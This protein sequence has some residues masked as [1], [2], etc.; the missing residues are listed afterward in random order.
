MNNRKSIGTAIALTL[1]FPFAGLIYS[2]AN[3][4][5]SWA[6]NAFW[7]AC[8]YLG[9]VFVFCPEGSILGM[10]SDAGRYA[11]SLMEMHNS[12]T[13][14]ST[15]FGQYLID[16]HTMDLYQPLMTYFISRFTDNAHVLFAVY[17][18]VFGFLYSRNIWYILDKLP[19]KKL[20][21]LFVLITLYFLV[22]PITQIN[23]ARM[24]TATHLF[25]YA[26][27]PY[28]LD[29]NKSRYWCVLLTPLIHFSFF[30]VAIFAVVWLFIPNNLKTRN[31]AA[32][33]I[34][35]ILFVSTMFFNELNLNSVSNVLAE[36][37]PE[38]YE[39][40][41]ES[42]VNEDIASRN[43]S[44]QAL[45]NW[46]VGASYKLES[47]CYNLLLLLLLP[48]IKR[49]FRNK[50]NIIHLYMFALILG[51]MA[52][53]MSFIPSGGRFQ[54]L[55]QLFKL[56]IIIMVAASVAVN[57]KFRQYINI[58]TVLLFLPFIFEIRKLFDYFSITA[59]L[60]NFITV[61]FWE[62]NV[63]LIDYIKYLL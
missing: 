2:L 32:L 55:S 35:M 51:S 62:N 52:N 16:E 59:I 28:L 47:W 39:E 60:G 46:Y 24:W 33:T 31:S 14:L 57:D 49:N 19:N 30:Y 34:A 8:V 58:A 13:S 22:C 26:V 61:F 41:I 5:A 63:P 15:I 7:M 40:R 29:N 27:M 4:K 18:F 44:A 1:F 11:L 25:V 12:N 50:K 20:S 43:A 48:C 54:I 53:V 45:T 56:P 9:A 42:Y 3:W 36:Y 6:K 37:S 10:G 23:A 17:A 38:A 21:Y